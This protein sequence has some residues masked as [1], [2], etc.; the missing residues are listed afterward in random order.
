MTIKEFLR[1][2][3]RLEHRI[4]M[5]KK[6][7]EELREL[8]TSIAS[9]GLEERY[10]ASRSREAPFEKVLMKITELEK[11]Q[12]DMLEKLLCFKQELMSVINSVSDKDERIVLHYRYVCNKTW[13]EIG[14]AMG[15]DERTIRRWHDKAVGHIALPEN[16]M[17]I[18]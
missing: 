4:R 17:V 10:N 16:P 9:P 15:W 6:E 18:D 13:V 5:H 12:A 3:Y 8:S 2:G 11:A 14:E 7:I 1:Q